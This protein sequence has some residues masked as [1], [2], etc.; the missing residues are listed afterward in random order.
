[1]KLFQRVSHLKILYWGYKM[2]I[3]LFENLKQVIQFSMFNY[4]NLFMWEKHQHGWHS[5]PVCIPK[6]VKGAK[7]YGKHCSSKYGSVYSFH[8]D[9]HDLPSSLFEPQPCLTLVEQLHIQN[10]EYRFSITLRR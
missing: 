3:P 10:G 1:M 5:I 4:C 2:V 9:V 7:T 8:G 6:M